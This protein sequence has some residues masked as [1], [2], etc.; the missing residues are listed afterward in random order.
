MQGIDAHGECMSRC[1]LGERYREG[2]RWGHAVGAKR[3]GP[4]SGFQW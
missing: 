1:R 2:L 3:W 4:C